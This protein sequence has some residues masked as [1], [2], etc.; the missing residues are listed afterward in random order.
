MLHQIWWQIMSL[1]AQGR[2]GEALLFLALAQ[3]FH[4]SFSDKTMETNFSKALE[5][6]FM[7]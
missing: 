5:N 1:A 4:L 6:T 2:M 3:L 7:E